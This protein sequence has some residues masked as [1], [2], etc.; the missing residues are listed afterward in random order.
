MCNVAHYAMEGLSEAAQ[1][2]ML[3]HALPCSSGSLRAFLGP[4]NGPQSA[5]LQASVLTSDI[6]QMKVRGVHG[7]QALSQPRGDRVLT[8]CLLA[9]PPGRICLQALQLRPRLPQAL[10]AAARQQRCQRRR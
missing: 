3:L 9:A 1:A 8:E 6:D 7:S 2:C 4:G 10:H 5:A